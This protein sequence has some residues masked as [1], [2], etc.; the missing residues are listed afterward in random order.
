MSSCTTYLSTPR[1]TSGPVRGH[2]GAAA[3]AQ[4]GRKSGLLSLVDERL[5]GVVPALPRAHPAL[6]PLED[7]SGLDAGLLGGS[8]RARRHRYQGSGQIRAKIYAKALLILLQRDRRKIRRV[9]HTE[10]T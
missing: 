5:S 9:F 2:L 6:A 10:L 4:R 8:D 7:A 1:R 3:C